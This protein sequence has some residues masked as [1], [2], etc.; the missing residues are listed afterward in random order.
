MSLEAGA[1]EGGI[2][3]LVIL[4]LML[5]ENENQSDPRGRGN[6]EIFKNFTPSAKSD[7][8]SLCA[9]WVDEGRSY[10]NLDSADTD[11]TGRMPMLTRVFAGC[12]CHFAL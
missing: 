11:Q 1:G 4:P 9:H 7:Q 3:L 12:T 5:E 6:F 2:H 8:S 10:L